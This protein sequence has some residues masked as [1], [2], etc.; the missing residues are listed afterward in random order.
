MLPAKFENRHIECPFYVMPKTNLQCI[1][2]FIFHT[3]QKHS[4]ESS[5]QNK[6]YATHQIKQEKEP[7]IKKTWIIL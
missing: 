7:I 1:K 6:K 3:F 5:K 2:R 4:I